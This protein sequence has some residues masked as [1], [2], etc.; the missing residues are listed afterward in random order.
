LTF[1][2]ISKF[3]KKP[4]VYDSHEYFTGV[5][6]IQNRPLVKYIWK[7]IEKS[8]FP[9]LNYVF[10]VNQSIANLYYK[11]YNI[12]PKV[13][14]NLPNISKIEKVKSRSE[15]GLPLNKPIVILQGAGINVDRGSEELLEAIAIQDQFFLCIVGKGDVIDKLKHRC[16]KNDLLNKV[17]FVNTLPYNEMMQY[18]LNADIGVSLDKD[19]NIN[20]KFSLPNKIFDYIKAEIPILASNLIE[21]SNIISTYQVGYTISEISSKSILNGLNIVL[22]TKEESYLKDRFK[23]AINDLNWE[24]E[25]RILIE[26]YKN[27]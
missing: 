8:I 22:K 15:L 10:T 3:K 23:H 13:L 18:T 16:K 20:H 2:I 5:A 14:R 12:L 7:T 17:I 6:E 24:K 4:L 9:R 19:N 25:S 21:V 1:W 26:T 11:D 27:F